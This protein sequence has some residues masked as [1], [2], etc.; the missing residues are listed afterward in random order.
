MNFA[1]D[2]ENLWGKVRLKMTSTQLAAFWSAMIVGFMA[3]G[4]VFFNRISYH[5]NTADLFA[6][7]STYE[8]NRWCL[9]LIY[10]FQLLSTKTFSL[11]LFNGLLSLLFIALAAMLLVDIFELKS[12]ASAIGVGAIMAVYPV[13]TSIFSFMF[14]SWPYFLALVLSVVAAGTLIKDR[15][16]AGFVKGTVCV[17]LMLGLYQAFLAV[18]ISIFLAKLLQDVIK[19][20]CPD[21]LTY[22]KNGLADLASLLA[23][24]VLNTLIATGLKYIR[25]ANTLEYKGRGDSYSLSAFPGKLIE[26]IREFFTASFAGVNGV[27]YLRLLTVCIIAAAIFQIVVLV[28]YLGKSISAK[29][30]GLVGSLLLPIGMNVVYLLS[31]SSDYY[32]DSLM[33]YGC[34]FVLIIPVTLIEGLGALSMEGDFSPGTI[35]IK[36]PL[37]K[38]LKLITWLQII[39]MVMVTF[40]YVYM[41]NAAYLK[42]SI[43]QEQATSYFN[44]LIACIKSTDGYREDMKVVFVGLGNNQ[45]ATFVDLDPGEQFNAVK[46]DN[47]PEY[48]D[49]VGY[50]AS[51]AFM[52]EHCGFGNELVSVDDGTYANNTQVKAMPTYPND[53]GIA[54]IDDKVIVKLGE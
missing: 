42:G 23:G 54:I 47:F 28:L 50:G 17:T 46:L 43:A 3:H 53:G 31:T 35:T 5:D 15:T 11:P 19:G 30:A 12:K 20:K 44:Q 7:G 26:A 18:T 52:R 21:I 32:V 34:A 25:H 14:T 37:G 45:D 6:L 27:R 10:D 38:A 8:V 2:I 22:T 1:S 41:D 39:A 16:L 48:F 49:L 36:K 40:G 24:L 13:V 4:F 29:V 9:G 51:L 33:V